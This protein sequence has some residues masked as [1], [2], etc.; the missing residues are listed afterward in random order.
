MRRE[1]RVFWLRGE[2]PVTGDARGAAGARLQGASPHTL[3]PAGSAARSLATPLG[4]WPPHST[5]E[6]ACPGTLLSDMGSVCPPSV[7]A[8]TCHPAGVEPPS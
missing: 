5:L 4:P 8:G 1:P 6:C 3:G 7:S 2:V